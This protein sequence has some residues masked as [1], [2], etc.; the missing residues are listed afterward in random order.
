M[1]EI[2]P[3]W[4]SLFT[5]DIKLDEGVEE[6]IYQ[7]RERDEGTLISTVGGWQSTRCNSVP[8]WGKVIFAQVQSDME[9]LYSEYGVAKTPE[10]SNYWVNINPPGGFNQTHTH[11]HSFMSGCLYIKA[12]KNCGNIVFDRPD[13]MLNFL[14]AGETNERNFGIWKERPEAG[15]VVYFT[16]DLPHSVMPN[17]STEDRISIAFNFR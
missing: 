2:R 11:P 3:F 7:L 16:S 5:K 6:N 12:Q 13:Q 4:S 8:D 17:Q 1:V 14:Q 9:W 15:K 10:L